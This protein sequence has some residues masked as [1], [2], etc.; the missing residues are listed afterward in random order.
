MLVQLNQRSQSTVSLDMRT[1]ALVPGVAVLLLT[2]C[3]SAPEQQT[4]SAP[5]APLSPQDSYTVQDYAF[6]PL[7]VAPGQVV[8]VLNADD[9]PHTVTADDG[10]FDTG[11]FDGGDPAGFTAPTQPG[12]YAFHC[13]VHPSMR[14]ALTVR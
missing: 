11:A 3:G 7:T 4:A 6:A 8:P 14:G 13:T 5:T 10:S 12:T 1:S 9:E 2:A